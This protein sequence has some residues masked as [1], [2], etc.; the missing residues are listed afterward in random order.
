MRL[1]KP[2]KGWRWHIIAREPRPPFD[3]YVTACGQGWRLGSVDVLELDYARSAG[4][5]CGACL[6]AD[7]KR[8]ANPG[9]RQRIERAL[10]DALAAISKAVGQ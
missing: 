5:Y 4:S 10:A 2:P 6:R 8:R 1:L 9:W 7:Q 3:E